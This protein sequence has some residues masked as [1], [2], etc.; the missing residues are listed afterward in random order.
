MFWAYIFT[1]KAIL[2]NSSEALESVFGRSG[3]DQDRL[4]DQTMT[5]FDAIPIEIK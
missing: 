5:L 3:V 2:R 4:V 1:A